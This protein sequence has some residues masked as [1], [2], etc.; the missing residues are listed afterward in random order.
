[1]TALIGKYA[2]DN[3]F[4][5]VTVCGCMPNACGGRWVEV[6][7]YDDASVARIEP[8]DRIEL[9][10]GRLFPPADEPKPG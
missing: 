8:F 2:E 10:V 3:A 6:G 5:T 4:A 9:E 7:S 1:M